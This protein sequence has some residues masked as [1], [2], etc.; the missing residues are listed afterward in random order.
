MHLPLVACGQGLDMLQTDGS[1]PPSPVVLPAPTPTTAEPAFESASGGTTA[2]TDWGNINSV[3]AGKI[4]E[5]FVLV[6]ANCVSPEVPL[7]NFDRH[8]GAGAEAVAAGQSLG[9]TAT[10]SIE[11]AKPSAGS[12]SATAV[13]CLQ[14]DTASTAAADK[15]S[16]ASKEFAAAAETLFVST[17]TAPTPKQGK[18]AECNQAVNSMRVT[19]KPIAEQYKIASQAAATDAQGFT[20]AVIVSGGSCKINSNARLGDGTQ[21]GADAAAESSGMSGTTGLLVGAGVGLGLGGLGG[22]LLGSSGDDDKD[23]EKKESTSTAEKKNN[24]A[25]GEVVNYQGVCV[26]APTATSGVGG[27]TEGGQA[28][29]TNVPVQM[30]G[31]APVDPATNLS[32]GKQD[33]VAAVGRNFSSGS[34]SSGSDN[35]VGNIG[36]GASGAAGRG[37]T[38]NLASVGGSAASSGFGGSGG[39]GSS[40]SPDKDKEDRAA[41]H[42]SAGGVD[43]MNCNKV[44]RFNK[45]TGRTEMV[46]NPNPRCKKPAPRA[47]GSALKRINRLKDKNAEL[48]NR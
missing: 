28:L 3:N 48:L 47:S 7:K 9:S 44:K 31:G 30:G 5:A 8:S 40:S 15:Y 4:V 1:P 16:E 13:S 45:A 38:R 22:Y 27:E 29:A 41:L 23:D 10:S 18:V 19:L 6:H 32:S 35:S 37:A 21:A 14:A 36:T 17:R 43:A 2:G 33:A 11:A 34:G 12:A 46:A 25:P 39:G 42:L 24:C 20:S 26:R